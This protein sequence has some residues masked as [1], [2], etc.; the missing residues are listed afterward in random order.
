MSFPS[1][2]ASTESDGTDTT[3]PSPSVSPFDVRTALPSFQN[4]SGTEATNRMKPKNTLLIEPRMLEPHDV[5]EVEVKE[6]A[7]ARSPLMY[8][9]DLEGGRGPCASL[10]AEQS[11]DATARLAHQEPWGAHMLAR[12]QPRF[13]SCCVPVPTVILWIDRPRRDP[14]GAQL[15]HYKREITFMKKTS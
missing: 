1:L 14:P 11:L 8:R 9:L 12:R 10:Y 2:P 15:I 7:M 6:S 5:L 4:R 3:A 13:K